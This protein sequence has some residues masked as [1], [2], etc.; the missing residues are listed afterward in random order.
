MN[1]AIQTTLVSRQYMSPVREG[2]HMALWEHWHESETL[3]LRIRKR[4]L[5]RYSSALSLLMA[6]ML[7]GTMDTCEVFPDDGRYFTIVWR[8]LLRTPQD[9]VP[10]VIIQFLDECSLISP[11]HKKEADSI[12][13]W[14][15]SNSSLPF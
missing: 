3:M 7:K 2:K 5:D 4:E 8:N 15:W 9:E 6:H 14:I 10:E 11:T 1:D 13:S 12:R